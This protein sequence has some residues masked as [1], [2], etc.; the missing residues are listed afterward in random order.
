MANAVHFRTLL[1]KNMHGWVPLHL[2][3]MPNVLIL[4]CRARKDIFILRCLLTKYRSC[5]WELT[6]FIFKISVL[7]ASKDQYLLIIDI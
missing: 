6:F 1:S 5:F 3:L 4:Y 2:L 7:T